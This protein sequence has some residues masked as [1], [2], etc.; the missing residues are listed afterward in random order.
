MDRFQLIREG[1]GL[2][3]VL[4]LVSEVSVSFEEGRFN[5]TQQFKFEGAISMPVQDV[6]RVCREIGDYLAIY[7][8]SIAMPPLIDHRKRI[9]DRIADLRTKRGW[10]Q[11]RLAEEVGTNQGNIARIESGKYNITLDRLQEIA[12]ALGGV[13]DIVKK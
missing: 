5:E 8:Y 11:Q 1:Q 10:T 4:D 7:H 13:I 9:G 3:K 2:Y 12:G 6:A